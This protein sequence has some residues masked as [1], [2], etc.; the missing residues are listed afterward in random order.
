MAQEEAML[1]VLSDTATFNVEGDTLTII[2]SGTVLV[3]EA[4]TA[5]S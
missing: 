1:Q 3:F 2:N 5:G 4:V